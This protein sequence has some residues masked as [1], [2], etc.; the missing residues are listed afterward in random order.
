MSLA[1]IAF[2]AA[3]ALAQE[4]DCT[5]EFFRVGRREN[6][7]Q[8]FFVCMVGGR[9]N[10]ACDDGDIFDE[11]L[12]TCREGNADTCDF[13]PTTPAPETTT[14]TGLLT[15]PAFATRLESISVESKYARQIEIIGD[16]CENY[17]LRIAPH[18][19]P[20]RCFEFFVCLN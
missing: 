15:P 13:A 18:P 20:V 4:I 3:P 14:A 16:E 9:I 7:C 19:N 11:D 1:L 12:I 2:A 10:F 17:F 5:E 6:S 8:D